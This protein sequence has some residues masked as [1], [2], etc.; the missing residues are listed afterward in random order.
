MASEL[1]RYTATVFRGLGPAPTPERRAELSRLPHFP[2]V[3]RTWRLASTAVL[4]FVGFGVLAVILRCALVFQTHYSSPLLASVSFPA[5]PATVTTVV[6]ETSTTTV[7]TS[8]PTTVSSTYTSV[9]PTT[10]VVVQTTTITSPITQIIQCKSGYHPAR[11]VPCER[12]GS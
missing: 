6:T 3:T 9:I 2:N 4:L 7:T 8:T 12:D 11:S 5:E 10:T 1:D